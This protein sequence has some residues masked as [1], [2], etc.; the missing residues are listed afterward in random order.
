MADEVVYHG[1]TSAV[2]YPATV[3]RC[4]SGEW[5]H[6]IYLCD[7]EEDCGDASDELNCAKGK[8]LH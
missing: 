2:E 4:G 8:P 6:R 3:I 5:I 1:S 7:G